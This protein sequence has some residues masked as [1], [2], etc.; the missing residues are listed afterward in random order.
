MSVSAKAGTGNQADDIASAVD[1][2]I[3]NPNNTTQAR[4]LNGDN[5]DSEWKCCICNV[6]SSKGEDT[7]MLNCNWCDEAKCLKCSKITKTKYNQLGGT[8]TMWFC[9]TSC[10]TATQAAITKSKTNIQTPDTVLIENRLTQKIDESKAIQETFRN[11]IIEK[12]NK[13]EQNLSTQTNHIE[14]VPTKV[15]NSWA[16]LVAKD[17][18]KQNTNTIQGQ[19]VA[20]SQTGFREIVKQALEDQ[21]KEDSLQ[22]ERDC[23]VIIHRLA[24]N[25]KENREARQKDEKETIDKFLEAIEVETVD[26]SNHHRCGLFNKEQTTPRPLKITFGSPLQRDKVM[27]HLKY[28]KNITDEDKAIF[29]HTSVSYDLSKDQRQQTKLLVDEAK[30]KT[31]GSLNSVWR[32]RGTPGNMR[33]VEYKRTTA[34]STAQ[35]TTPQEN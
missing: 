32:V 31:N 19:G 30:A 34:P 17:A 28:L 4:V 8:D 24:E 35:S 20:K 16:E 18:P 27:E 29:T 14:N 11:E 26:I 9:T 22:H 2:N 13:L 5:G 12:L 33:I 1:V 7:P 6:V 10:A 21:K 15:T 23:S 25:N 3:D